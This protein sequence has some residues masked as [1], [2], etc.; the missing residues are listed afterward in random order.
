MPRLKPGD[1]PLTPEEDAIVEAAIRDDPDTFELDAEWFAG[2]RPAVQTLP[3]EVGKTIA[4][5]SASMARTCQHS[6]FGI[7]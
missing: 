2:A 5:E 7:E 4:A 3:R 6:N 1:K